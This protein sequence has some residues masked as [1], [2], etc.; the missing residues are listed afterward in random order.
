MR[1]EFRVHTDHGSFLVT[2]TDMFTGFGDLGAL[3]VVA[4]VLIGVYLL[5]G[6]PIVVWPFLRDEFREMFESDTPFWTLVG[7]QVAFTMFRIV[8]NIA[9]GES[10]FILELVLQALVFMIAFEGVQCVAFYHALQTVDPMILREA[11]ITDLSFWG[12]TL[13]HI[14]TTYNSFG[15]LLGTAYVSYTGGAIPAAVTCLVSNVLG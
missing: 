3:V 6:T 5:F 14:T 4:L 10:S 13:Q 9:K 1:E 2:I 8:V 7:I 15:M 12:L 11:G